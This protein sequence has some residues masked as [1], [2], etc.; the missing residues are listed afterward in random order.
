VPGAIQTKVARSTCRFNLGIMSENGDRWWAGM[1]DDRLWRAV[2]ACQAQPG[3]SQI[4]AYIHALVNADFGIA[5]RRVNGSMEFKTVTF[6]GVAG[7]GLPVFSNKASWQGFESVLEGFS[8]L[9]TLRGA[10]LCKLIMSTMPQINALMIDPAR[11]DFL[12][13]PRNTIETL[14]KAKLQ[15]LD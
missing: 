13:L 2:A 4:E 10:P 14:S 8:E 6:P 3:E 9:R 7:L 5:F 15:D 1:G 11:P 12:K